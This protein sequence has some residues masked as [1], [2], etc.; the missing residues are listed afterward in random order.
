MRATESP[1][2]CK[3]DECRGMDIILFELDLFEARSSSRE[4]RRGTV[5]VT[6]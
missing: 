6:Q 3:C 5:A 4:T 2:R 1:R